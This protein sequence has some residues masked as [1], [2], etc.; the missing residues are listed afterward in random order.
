MEKE[1]R[2]ERMLDYLE[3]TPMGEIAEKIINY[4]D[5]LDLIKH[6]INDKNMLYFASKCLGKDNA[7]LY[8]Y[9]KDIKEIV[10]ND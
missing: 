6:I 3:E 2:V 7:V 8:E 9:I 1:I 5:K 4:E 10:E